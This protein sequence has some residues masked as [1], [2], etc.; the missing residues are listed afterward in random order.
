LEVDCGVE[1]GLLWWRVEGGYKAVDTL[2]IFF[3]YDVE[4]G[5]FLGH[6]PV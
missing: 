4:G 1:E 6:V 3:C 2:E 5:A